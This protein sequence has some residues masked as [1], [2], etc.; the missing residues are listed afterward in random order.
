LW[1]PPGD[2]G[3]VPPL[4]GSKREVAL[5]MATLKS[6]ERSRVHHQFHSTISEPINAIVREMKRPRAR[7]RPKAQPTAARSGSAPPPALALD[8][9]R[10]AIY[11]VYMAVHKSSGYSVSFLP[12]GLGLTRSRV[13]PRRA[14]LTTLR[15]SFVPV[16][17]KKAPSQWSVLRCGTVQMRQCVLNRR[18]G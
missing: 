4:L 7:S 14:L 15:P 13:T 16:G 10:P 6:L 1:I 5:W 2:F 3:R 17:V 11:H 8:R 18:R 12:P 9:L